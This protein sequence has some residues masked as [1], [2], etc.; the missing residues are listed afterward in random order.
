MAGI[1]VRRMAHAKGRRLEPASPVQGRDAL[2]SATALGLTA[3]LQEL[4]GLGQIPQRWGAFMRASIQVG[5]RLQEDQASQRVW[6]CFS[7][8]G[9]DGSHLGA[10]FLKR[11]GICAWT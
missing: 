3:V 7:K 4:G 1:P 11:L 2:A 9:A 10:C 8:W 6:T 5:Q